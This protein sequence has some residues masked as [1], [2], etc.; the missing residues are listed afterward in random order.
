MKDIYYIPNVRATACTFPMSPNE[1]LVTRIEVDP[2]LR[3]RGYG[4]E[5]LR[6]ITRDADAEKVTLV[7]E[8]EPDG[9][10]NGLGFYELRVWYA[11][12]GFVTHPDS[13]EA[14][15]RYPRSSS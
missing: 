1:V 14:M 6:R 12:L 3:G 2:A 5:L 15:I 10:P 7:L 4:T 13:N 9:S 11:K 8:V